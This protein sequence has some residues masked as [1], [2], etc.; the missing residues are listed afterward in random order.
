M[1]REPTNAERHAPSTVYEELN[2]TLQAV[3]EVALITS[4]EYPLA[5]FNPLFVEPVDDLNCVAGKLDQYDTY[6]FTYRA[7]YA[8]EARTEIAL[9]V[10]RQNPNNENPYTTDYI[11]ANDGYLYAMLEDREGQPTVL[12]LDEE[13]TKTILDDIRACHVRSMA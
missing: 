2:I 12:R 1:E 3:N 6:H 10:E 13:E 7:T 8:N 4:A 11:A 9:Q 5:S